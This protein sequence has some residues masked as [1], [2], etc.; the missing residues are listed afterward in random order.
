MEFNANGQVLRVSLES[1]TVAGWTGRD[2]DAVHHHIDELKE[3][4]VAPP[5]RVPL[6]YQVSPA[7][8]THQD[9]ISV[10]G[11][12]TSGEVEP[13]LFH[14]NGELWLGLASDH[15]DRDLETV[16]VAASKQACAKPCA[17]ELWR[18]ADIAGHLDELV[19]ACQINE[20]G[21]LVDYQAG[22]LSAI[23]PLDDLTQAHPLS[24]NSAML[25][26]TLGAIGGVRPSNHYVM[27]L[28][29]PV[30]NRTLS[31]DYGVTTLEIVQ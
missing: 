6:F 14:A 9:Q 3:I 16:S 12:A 8:L 4:G 5:S 10:L 20:E 15:T 2:T 25:C 21:Q 19:L 1:L 23:R 11:E 30:L 7:L 17:T 22:A 18:Y 29:D 13:L 31:L 27:S 28:H 24:D 26:G